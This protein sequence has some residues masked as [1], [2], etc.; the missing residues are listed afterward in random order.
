MNKAELED[1]LEKACEDIGDMIEKLTEQQL[2][3]A[4][5]EGVIDGADVKPKRSGP[6]VIGPGPTEEE[7]RE[8]AKEFGDCDEECECPRCVAQNE[9]M[10]EAHGRQKVENLRSSSRDIRRWAQKHNVKVEDGDCND[11]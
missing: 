8:F 9:R 11:N 2:R 3:I 6:M 7:M 4:Y 5:L 1:R 10:I